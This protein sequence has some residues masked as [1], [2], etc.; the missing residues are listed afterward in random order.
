MGLFLV[1]HSYEVWRKVFK[2]RKYNGN[3]RTPWLCI[4][5]SVFF[6]AIGVTGGRCIATEPLSPFD[7]ASEQLPRHAD[8]AQNQLMSPV[9]GLGTLSQPQKTEEIQKKNITNSVSPLGQTLKIMLDPGHGGKDD[10]AAGRYGIR[11]KQVALNLAKKVKREVERIAKYQGYSVDVNLT[12]EN[13]VFIP[14]KERVRLANE[15]GSDVFVSIHLNSSPVPRARGFEV[16]FLSPEASDPET[17]RLALKES[18]GQLPADKSDVLSIISDVRTTFHTQ[19]SAAFAE[20]MFSSISK[21]ISSN[22]RGVR[23]GPF[24]VLHGTNM[25]AILVEVGYV[26]HFQESL[27]L[28]KEAYLKRLA[29]AI[30]SG[31]IDYGLRT[32]KLG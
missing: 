6:V 12:R 1:H 31:I 5:F 4:P 10:G 18:D 24:T 27:S 15:S 30:S 13:D 8:P 14:L 25:P 21:T 23:Q 9:N 29:S 19:E 7:L 28:T 17:E 16:Y 20:E 32:K 2:S 11:E 3:T 22:G 26:T